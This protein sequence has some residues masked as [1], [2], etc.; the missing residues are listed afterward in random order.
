MIV[1]LL[2]SMLYPKQECP[3]KISEDI[4]QLPIAFLEKKS[5]LEN[6]KHYQDNWKKYSQS[7]F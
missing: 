6:T 3:E 1:D 2:N 7:I 5:V 4:F